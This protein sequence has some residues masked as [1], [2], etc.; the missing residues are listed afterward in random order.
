MYYETAVTINAEADQ[1]WSVLR[2]V[3]RWPEWT[4]TVTSV[5][6]SDGELRIGSVARIRQPRLP[7]ADWTVHDLTPGSGFAW[8]ATAAGMTTVGDHRITPTPDG[9]GV[10]VTL[11]LRQSGPLAPLV[12]LFMG[13]LVRRYVDTEAQRLRERCETPTSSSAS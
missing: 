12:G 6:V 13:R 5:Q 9:S 1:V 2:D 10:G 3:E 11:S 7:M 8:T 4:P